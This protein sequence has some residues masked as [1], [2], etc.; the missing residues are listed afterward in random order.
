MKW[1]KRIILALCTLVLTYAWLGFLVLPSAGLWVINQQL[2]QYSSEPAQLHRLE[3]NPFTLELNLWQLQVGAEQPTLALAHARA[4]LA[5][6]S[7]KQRHVHVS[8]LHLQ[9]PDLRVMLDA[10]G[11]LNLQQLLVLPE[12][13]PDAEPKPARNSLLVYVDSL[14]LDQGR[15]HFSDQRQ[16]QPV[17]VTF[18]AIQ[19]QVTDFSTAEQ[20]Q[21]HI[22]ATLS[23]DD[24]SQLSWDGQAS[25]SPVISSGQLTV[26]QLPLTTWWPYVQA[27]VPLKLKQGRAR[28]HTDYHFQLQPELQLSTQA[29]KL[30]IHDLHLADSRQPLLLIKRLGVDQVAFNLREQRLH[31]GQLDGASIESWISLDPQGQLNW[32]APFAGDATKPSANTTTPASATAKPF[33]LAQI[34][35]HI[36]LARATLASNQLHIQDRSRASPVTLELDQLALELSDFD[37][38]SDQPISLK[39]STQVDEQGQLDLTAQIKPQSHTGQATLNSRDL[40]LRP[41]ES[42]ITPYAKI[43]LLSAF[44]STQLSAELKQL[45]P[46]Q[47]TAQGSLELSQLHVREQQ[48]HNDLLKVQALQLQELSFNQADT[49]QLSIARVVA[50]QPYV[51]FIID[52]Q[53]RSNLSKVIVPQPEPSTPPEP[54]LDFAFNVDEILL[55]DGSANFADLSLKPNFSTAIHK[56]G[57]RIGRIDSTKSLST[58]IEITGAVDNY[59]PVNIHGSATPF[60]PFQQ[61]D[62]NVEFNRLE[63]TALTPYSGK[64]AGYR[65]HKGRLNLAL[66]YQIN[67]GQL[68][69]DHSVL[70]EQLQLGERVDSP[71]ALNLPVRLAVAMLK[72]TKGDISLQLPVQGDLKNPEFKVMPIVWQTLRNL[73]TRAVSAPFKLLGSIGNGSDLDL[74][75]VPFNPGDERIN[76]AAT[77]VLRDL[78][79]ALQ[80]RPEL[81]LNIEGTSSANLDGPVV[82]ERLLTRHLQELWAQQQQQRGKKNPADIY[83]VEISEKEQAKLLQT[84]FEALAEQ[85][86]LPPPEPALRK[87]ELLH[88]QREQLLAHL[89]NDSLSLRTLAQQRAAAIRQYLAEQGDVKVERLY[90]IDVNEKIDPVTTTVNS[91]LHVDAL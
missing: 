29:L 43:D 47:L 62:L 11:Q 75:Q 84:L 8:S 88:W 10:H 34:P 52:E 1:F 49:R 90:L 69:A 46:L 37:S 73:L 21:A 71:D 26:E 40:D 38:R 72:D 80:Q 54:G 70:L 58:P 85:H 27:H 31:V 24:G 57:G 81:R 53:L 20:H 45:A 51:R 13:A 9:A 79:Q 22:T 55:E 48:Q 61:L 19:L 3:L 2:N 78:A 68:N 59:A 6:D 36:T 74:S 50:K 89:A 18:D 83:S 5:W 28:L 77:A 41:A 86:S 64:F 42:W 56:L 63:L 91:L 4:Q 82:A 76:P 23:A 14:T 16:Q 39:L 32:Q 7:L 25:L 60:D 12:K 44:L 17:A 15:V 65:I 87:A 66:H 35:W 33:S 67:Q 30:S